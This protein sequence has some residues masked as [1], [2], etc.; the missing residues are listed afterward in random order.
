[1]IFVGKA[2]EVVVDPRFFVPCSCRG[3]ASKQDLNK[4]TIESGPLSCA[5]SDGGSHYGDELSEPN[6][7][8]DSLD[9]RLDDSCYS[10]VTNSPSHDHHSSSLLLH[11]HLP[12]DDHLS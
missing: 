5:A 3:S 11:H 9:N 4:A 1:M 8:D 2:G 6:E 7:S 12:S 10:S